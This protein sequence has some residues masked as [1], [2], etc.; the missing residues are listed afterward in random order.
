MVGI[1]VGRLRQAGDFQHGPRQ[2]VHQ[3][4]LHGASAGSGRTGVNGR[5]GALDA[6]PL[7]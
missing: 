3:R 7:H 1:S 5:A 6:Q 2:P 4:D